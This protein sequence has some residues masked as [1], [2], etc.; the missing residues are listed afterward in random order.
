MI[1]MSGWKADRNGIVTI[2]GEE[3]RV[4]VTRG[5]SCSG[6]LEDGMMVERLYDADGR[7][8]EEKRTP[9]NEWNQI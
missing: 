3:W 7:L 5:P 2:D 6:F 9:F 1:S 8:V 4:R